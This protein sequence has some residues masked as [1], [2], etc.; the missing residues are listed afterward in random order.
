MLDISVDTADP[1]SADAV[2][3]LAEYYALL[4]DA[5]GTPFE[6]SKSL[7]PDRNALRPPQGGFWVA[8]Q[9][10]APVGC[11]GLK[12][13][14]SETGEIKRLWI[15][16]STRGKGLATQLM[17]TAEDEART[18]GMTRLRLDTN[19]TLTAAIAMYHRLGW[20]EI[21]AFNDEPYAHHWFEKQL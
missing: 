9:Q 2:W 15:A 1:E 21:P 19:R 20:T 6:V 16:E 4:S 17:K 7:D 18:L 12:G 13:N 14:G 8:R 10:G 5:M 3:C 11:C